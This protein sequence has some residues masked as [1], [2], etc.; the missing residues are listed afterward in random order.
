MENNGLD[1]NGYIRSEGSLAKIPE[2]FVVL[3]EAVKCAIVSAFEL[4]LHSLYIYG[5]VA[6]GNARALTSDLDMLIVFKTDLSPQVGEAVI[7]LENDLSQRFQNDVREVGLAATSVSEIF[8]GDNQIGWGCFIKHMCVCLTGE[9]LGTRL[10]KFRPT[11][12]VAYG[13][14]GDLKQEIA[15]A[16]RAML[17]GL[18]GNINRTVRSISRKM[19]RTAF[20]LVMEEANCWTTDLSECSSIFSTYYPEHTTQIQRILQISK[21]APANY[22]ELLNTLNGFGQW[23][24]EEVEHKL[25]ST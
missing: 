23:L 20:C 1:E 21:G 5:S 25:R 18:P 15:E 9:D 12:A 16:R 24:C 17:D 14:N 19:I 11:K 4:Q 3:V 13:L 7:Q 10:P 6:S 22:D 8:D 2:R